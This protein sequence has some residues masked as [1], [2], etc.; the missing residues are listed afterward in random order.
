[1][2]SK[3]DQ[4]YPYGLT[5]VSHHVPSTSAQKNFRRPEQRLLSKRLLHIDLGI[6]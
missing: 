3:A 2:D 1:M 5:I 6:F 4:N